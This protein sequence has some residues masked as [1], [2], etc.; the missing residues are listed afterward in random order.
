[1]E[2]VAHQASEQTEGN[3]SKVDLRKERTIIKCSPEFL[4]FSLQKFHKYFTSI[5]VYLQQPSA[6]LPPAPI[7]D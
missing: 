3:W 4:V 5:R 1:M 6:T 2:F 7:N